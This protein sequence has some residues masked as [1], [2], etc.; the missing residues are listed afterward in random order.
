LRGIAADDGGD[1][2]ADAE[3]GQ[4]RAHPQASQPKAPDPEQVPAR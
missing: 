2:D 1:A 3:R 4:R